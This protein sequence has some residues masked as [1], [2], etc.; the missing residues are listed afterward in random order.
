MKRKTTKEILAESFH[1]LANKKNVEKIT[2]KDI[3]DNCGFS[4]ATF[5]RHFNDKYDLMAWDYIHSTG[6]IMARIGNEGY[7]WE[8]TLTD[9]MKYY[10]GIRAYLKNLLVNTSGHDAFARRMSAINADLLLHEV[11]KATGQDGVDPDTVK[12]IKIY[13]YGMVQLVCEWITGGFELDPE[14]MAD[15][16]KNALPLPLRE[17]LMT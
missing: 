6:E 5:Y 12:Y 17:Y 8:D 7:V 9:G 13:C 10:Y 14:E 16:C 11:Q 1:E 15:I 3:T 4:P 2:I